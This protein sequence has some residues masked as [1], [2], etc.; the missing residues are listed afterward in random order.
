MNAA[1]TFPFYM[2]PVGGQWFVMSS[3]EKEVGMRQ[4]VLTYL[5]IVNLIA[6]FLYGID[7]GKAKR[8]KWRIS[9]K[10]LIGIAV[11]GGS[12]GAVLGMQVFRHKTR[13]WYFRYGLPAIL[14]FQVVL[15]VF[16]RYRR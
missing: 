3:E 9:E 2:V 5:I 13:H 1:S 8:G 12:I 11:I 16:L 15:C 14:V 6:F 7:K 4:V 10:T